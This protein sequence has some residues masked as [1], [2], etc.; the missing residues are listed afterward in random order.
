MSTFVTTHSWD[1]TDTCEWCRAD[2]QDVLA[3]GESCRLAPPLP[4]RRPR[5]AAVVDE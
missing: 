3:V 5:L 1:A 2:L 4:D